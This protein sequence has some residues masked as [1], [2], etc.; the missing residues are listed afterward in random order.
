MPDY[1][2][3]MHTDTVEDHAVPDWGAYL[4][5]LRSVGALRGGSA[6]G[7]GLC[8]RRTGPIPDTTKHL[9][10]FIRI[11]ARDTEHARA[12]MEGNPVL[13]A[14]GTVEIRELPRTD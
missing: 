4:D 5:S 3:F 6:I 10:G 14:G 8:L 2:V 9:A 1:I 11:E 13:E 12:L 7:P